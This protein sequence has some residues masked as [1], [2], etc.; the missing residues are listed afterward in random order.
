MRHWVLL[1][2][3][4]V[5]QRIVKDIGITMAHMLMLRILRMA[6]LW[7]CQLQLSLSKRESC[8][9]LFLKQMVVLFFVVI[10][11]IPHRRVDSPGIAIVGR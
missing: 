4:A 10:T 5:L 3:A 2:T 8:G 6:R 9:V 7:S 1:A 11:T